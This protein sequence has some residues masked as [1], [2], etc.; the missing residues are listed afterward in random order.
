MDYQVIK[1][2][3]GD[4]LFAVE[5]EPAGPL[6]SG[7]VEAATDKLRDVG[8]AIARSCGDIFSAVHDGAVDAMPQELEVSFGVT[9]SAEAGMY[10]LKAS[11][12]STFTVTA[13]WTNL[14]KSVG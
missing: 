4:P 6:R 2:E 5:V 13:R 8:D 14:G 7:G 11:G 10:V 12:E 3:N 1:D 9:L